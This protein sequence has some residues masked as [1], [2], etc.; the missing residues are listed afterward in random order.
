[1]YHNGAT[2]DHDVSLQ[3]HYG[4][5]WLTME[6]VWKHNGT[7]MEPLRTTMDQHASTVAHNGPQWNHYG[8][9]FGL[10]MEPL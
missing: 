9:H 6:P 5:L 10:L 2:M 3:N 7:T 1:M 8:D 4:P